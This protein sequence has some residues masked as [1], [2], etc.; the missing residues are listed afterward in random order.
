[1]AFIPEFEAACATDHGISVRFRFTSSG[2]RL[3]DEEIADVLRRFPDADVFI[4]GPEPYMGQVIAAL[5]A[6][7]VPPARIFQERFDHAGAPVKKTV[8]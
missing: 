7:G 6:E 8:A 5:A 4:C 2:A 3:C 1:M